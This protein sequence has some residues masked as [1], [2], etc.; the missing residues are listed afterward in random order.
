MK[1]VRSAFEGVLGNLIYALIVVVF[2]TYL[3]RI[4]SVWQ[5]PLMNGLMAGFLVIGIILLSKTIARLPKKYEP[6]TIDNIEFRVRLWLDNFRLGVKNSPIKDSH[7]HYIVTTEGGRNIGI[8]RL[9]PT[10]SF[11]PVG[12]LV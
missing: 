6:T 4:A 12:L 11:V 3:S 8:V 10:R 2:I 9:W 7:F 5:K 1:T